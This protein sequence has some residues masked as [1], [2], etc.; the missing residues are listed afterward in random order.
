MKYIQSIPIDT[1]YGISK[2]VEYDGNS[3]RVM[4]GAP[5]SFISTWG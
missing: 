1:E 5:L 2:N 3:A 4:E